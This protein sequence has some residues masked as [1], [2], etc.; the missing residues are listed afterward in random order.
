MRSSER[1]DW[2]KKLLCTMEDGVTSITVGRK[3]PYV[4]TKLAANIT[5]FYNIT[6]FDYFQSEYLLQPFLSLC[7]MCRVKITA[8]LSIELII[9]FADS[10]ASLS[11]PCLAIIIDSAGDF[12]G[13][14]E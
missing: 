8:P 7:L 12:G 10:N 13:L 1:I 14:I 3:T 2:F 11:N 9:L 4:E 6:G 5:S